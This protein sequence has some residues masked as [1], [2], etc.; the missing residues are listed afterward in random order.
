MFRTSLSRFTCYVTACRMF[1][2]IFLDCWQYSSMY[3]Y[4]VIASSAMSMMSVIHSTMVSSEK[5]P[6]AIHIAVPPAILG[7][8][9]AFTARPN[10]VSSFFLR[11]PIPFLSPISCIGAVANTSSLLSMQFYDSSSD[12][13]TAYYI[14]FPLF[15]FLLVMPIWLSS[16]SARSSHSK[17]AGVPI[18]GGTPELF[19]VSVL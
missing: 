18:E 4:Y 15:L 11:L 17:V 12:S 3:C 9:G 2:L 13:T 6:I 14:F 5:V 16:P 10:Y 1:V 7:V 19:T 8:G